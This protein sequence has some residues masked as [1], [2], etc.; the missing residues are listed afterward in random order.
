MAGGLRGPGMVLGGLLLC[1]FPL[2]CGCGHSANDS[3]EVESP[4]YVR[5][6]AGNLFDTAPIRGALRPLRNRRSGF[7]YRCSECHEDLDS[8]RPAQELLGEHAHVQVAFDHGMNTV[9]FNCHHEEDRNAYVDH[10]GRPIPSD[11]PARLCGK[12]HGPIYRE[13]QHGAHGRQNGYWDTSKGPRERLLC[14]Q[15][16]DPHAPAFPKMTPDPP[17]AYS[18]FAQTKQDTHE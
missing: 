16:H 2:A 6:V 7:A 8:G 12:C 17:P 14:V 4:L 15:C 10:D 9:C 3:G 18:R 5:P 11:E 1:A 13:W